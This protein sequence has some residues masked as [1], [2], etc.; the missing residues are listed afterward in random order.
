M[1]LLES[2]GTLENLRAFRE[3]FE[4]LWNLLKAWNEMRIS[5][6]KQTKNIRTYR[7]AFP[8]IKIL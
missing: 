1:E 2:Y 3:L 6:L 8:Q 7:A 4:T 5:M